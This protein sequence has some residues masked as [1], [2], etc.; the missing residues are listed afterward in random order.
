V[1]DYQGRL[2][3]TL[4]GLDQL[5]QLDDR[6]ASIESRADNVREAIAGIGNELSANLGKKNKALRDLVDTRDERLSSQG[7]VRSTA[8]R[9]NAQTGRYL[10]GPNVNARRLARARLDAAE[11]ETKNAQLELGQALQERRDIIR[12]G[13][14]LQQRTLPSLVLGGDRVAEKRERTLRG[15]TESA[16]STNQQLRLGSFEAQYERRLQAFRRGGGGTNAP[17]LIEKVFA[18]TQAYNAQK[19]VISATGDTSAKVTRRQAAELNTL[20]S[21]LGRYNEAQLEANRRARSRVERLS[22]ARKLG[23]RLRPME[24]ASGTARDPKTGELLYPDVTRPAFPR[25]EVG[26]ARLLV[27]RAASAAESGDQELFRLASFQAKKIIDRMEAGAKAGLKTAR[28]AQS[29]IDAA[30]KTA[31]NAVDKGLVTEVSLSDRTFNDRLRESKERAKREED[32]FKASSKEAGKDFDQRL[33]NRVKQRQTEQRAAVRDLNARSS[34]QTA[35]GEMERRKTVSERDSAKR[36]R[37]KS[38]AEEKRQRDLGIGV[39]APARISGSTRRVN[40]IPMRG[41]TDSGIMPRAL[42]NDKL[43][44][45]RIAGTVGGVAPVDLLKLKKERDKQEEKRIKE[46]TKAAQNRPKRLREKLLEEER[47]Q[48]K[49]GIGVNAPARIGGPVRR[50]GAIPMSGGTDSGIMPRALPSQKAL[51]QRIALSGQR[52]PTRLDRLKEDQEKAASE[53][54]KQAD[55]ELEQSGRRLA[56]AREAEAK[57]LAEQGLGP[58][59]RETRAQ[60]RMNAARRGA[61]GGSGGGGGR[62]GGGI[63]MPGE[64][65]PIPGD[66]GYNQYPYL[67]GPGSPVGIGEFQRIQKAKR[68]Q[69]RQQGQQK[70]FF[71][72][73]LR[74]AA[75]RADPPDQPLLRTRNRFV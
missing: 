47:R 14:R 56:K 23:D 31:K 35:L 38:L 48:E 58:G 46:E 19:R 61:G 75:G 60:S 54:R 40:A 72:G 39:D 7:S 64:G 25:R 50:T 16:S 57:R 26:K 43:L 18:I 68:E 29:R 52:Q 49:L 65:F 69:Q 71:Q 24:A 36:F 17:G 33:Q 44:A 74:S 66:S 8:Q 2:K 10:Q 21:A 5:K 42:P 9:R 51:E 6:L 15:V 32:L 3:V 27:N 20:S 1:S 30:V 45:A 73:D 13:R 63:A 12:R 41:G 37:E 11:A 67:A 28:T 34:W 70:G 4:Q 55:K 62:R 53:R 59:T 22:A